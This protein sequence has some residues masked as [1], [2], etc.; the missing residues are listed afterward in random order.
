MR[1]ERGIQIHSYRGHRIEVRDDGGD[2]WAVVVHPR[3]GDRGAAATLRSGMPNGL[4]GLL[5]EARRRVDRRLDAGSGGF[6]A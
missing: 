2:G 4:A 5:A 1:R 6:R 3:L